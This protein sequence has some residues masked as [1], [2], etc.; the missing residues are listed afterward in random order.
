ME[1]E[2]RGMDGTGERAIK[3]GDRL[4]PVFILLTRLREAAEK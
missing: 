1:T 2:V 3:P 4:V